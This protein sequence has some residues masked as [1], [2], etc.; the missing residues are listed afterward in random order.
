MQYAA[1]VSM[2]CVYMKQGGKTWETHN[3]HFTYP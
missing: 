3:I 2:L 1:C